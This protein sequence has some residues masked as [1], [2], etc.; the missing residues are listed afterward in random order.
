MKYGQALTMKVEGY[1]ER[2]RG[3]GTTDAKATAAYFV[4]PGETV[5]GIFVGRKQGVARLGDAVVTAPSPDRVKPECPHAGSCG[6]CAW[7]HVAYERQLK[8][9]V[10]MIDAAFADAKIPLSVGRAVPAAE[11]FHHRNRMDYV[12]GPKGELGLKEPGRWDKHLDLSTCLMLSADGFE[13]LKRVRDWAKTTSHQPWDNRRHQGFLKYLVIR[14]G[15][16]SGERIATL[17]TAAGELEKEKELV[18]ALDPLCTSIVHGV[19]PTITD[20]S[21]S[22]TLRPLKGEALLREK[23]GGVSY[24][25]HPNAFFQ[26]NSRMAA[27]LLEEVK[28][29]VKSGTH[30]KLLDLYCGGGFFSLGLAKDVE[31]A[32]GVE[33]DAPAIEQAKL[34]AEENGIA[35]VRYLAEAAEKLSWE[36]EAPDVVIVDP[37]RSGLHPEVRRTLLAKRPERI[38]YVSCNFRTL[39]TDLKDLLRAYAAEPAVAVDLFPHTPHIE[40]LVHLTRI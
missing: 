13:V 40:T 6:G 14:E 7:Q 12:F 1:D 29:F 18:D 26:T 39:A 4:I 19:N 2:G 38:V 22:A 23:I 8:E 31:T 11:R 25:I 5:D 3:I 34:T 10:A 16:F 30:A 33:L 17:V 27:V 20:I 36:A 28:A 9:K 37:P 21:V 35:N 15:K 32:L 24:R